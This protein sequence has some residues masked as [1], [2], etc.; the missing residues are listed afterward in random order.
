[1]DFLLKIFACK[2][3]CSVFTVLCMFIYI[4]FI[5]GNIPNWIFVTLQNSLNYN[6]SVSLIGRI[7][8]C[9]MG[10][11]FLVAE[12]GSSHTEDNTSP[13]RSFPFFSSKT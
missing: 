5:F 10:I 3:L 6:K 13:G 12:A 1:M 9:D 2:Y 8:D 11:I 4:L 7:D